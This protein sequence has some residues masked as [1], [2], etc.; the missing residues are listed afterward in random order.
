MNLID[1]TVFHKIWKEGI[2]VRHDDTGL[3]VRFGETE[4]RFLYPDSFERYLTFADPVLQLQV[5]K[6]LQEKVTAETIERERRQ[7]ETAEMYRPE[8]ARSAKAREKKP[9][10]AFKCNYCDGG[11]NRYHIGF[12]GACSDKM[13]RYNVQVAQHSW[14]S[15]PSCPCCQYLN[16]E[17]D[18]YQLDEQCRDGGFVCYESQM[19]RDWTAFAGFMLTEGRKEEPKRIRNAQPKSLAI[20]TTRLPDTPEEERVIFGVFLVDDLD[21]GDDRAEGFVK[22]MSKY[23]LELTPDEAGEIKFWKYHANDKNPEKAAWSQGLYRYTDD[24]EAAQILR[25]I[26]AVKKL[27]SGKQFAEEFFAHF[28]TIKALDPNS[29]PAPNGALKR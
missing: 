3:Y 10:M 18:G 21:E 9:N 14:C 22:S 25:D 2:V 15:D 16:G 8:P 4:K 27:A 11:S 6:Q 23:R 12:M 7:K 17:I 5:L 19:L 29:I 20:L 24:V 28:C 13:I 1:Q 26:A